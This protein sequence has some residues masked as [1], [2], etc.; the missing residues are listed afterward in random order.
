MMND[1]FGFLGMPQHLGPNGGIVSPYAAQGGMAALYGASLAEQ[2]APVQA[3]MNALRNAA[4]DRL[5]EK[6]VC[7]H[8]QK[9][10]RIRGKRTVRKWMASGDVHVA[11]GDACTNCFLTERPRWFFILYGLGLM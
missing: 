6:Q 3:Q 9:V 7:V 11:S 1:P 5:V 10:R 8:C 4:M 2:L